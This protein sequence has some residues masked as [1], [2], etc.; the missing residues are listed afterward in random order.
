MDNDTLSIV[1]GYLDLGDVVTCLL[2]NRQFNYVIMNKYVW[3]HLLQRDFGNYNPILKQDTS[4]ET[5]KLCHSLDKLNR[6]YK[7][8][9]TI[10]ELSSLKEVDLHYKGIIDVPIVLGKLT[11]L[12]TLYL[13]SNQIVTVPSELFQLTNLRRLGLGN[14]KILKI[15]PE[16]GKLVN[17]QDLY[18]DNN[19]LTEVPIEL[20]QLVNLQDLNLDNNRLT[21]I[22]R[23]FG[24]LKSLQR[25]RL[26][27]NQLTELL[28]ERSEQAA[29]PMELGVFPH[30]RISV[31]KNPL[32]G[33]PIE[34]KHLY[35][36]PY[37]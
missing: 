21:W 13:Q 29:R 31:G 14:N 16:I 23:E 10:N 28:R 15:P 30:S 6:R 11:N 1:F 20:C 8:A 22:P 35:I 9:E 18:L 32:K 7:I 36:N 24:N 37:L 25:L 26:F 4:L 3:Y 17:L 27:N 12:T 33:I 19:Q 34:L 5:Y 2:V